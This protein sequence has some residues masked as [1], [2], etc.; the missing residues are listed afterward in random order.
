MDRLVKEMADNPTVQPFTPVVH[1]TRKRYATHL[2][3]TLSGMPLSPHATP[4]LHSQTPQTLAAAGGFT[5]ASTFFRLARELKDAQVELE[6][7]RGE[8]LHRQAD[9]ADRD[10]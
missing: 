9:G 1:R 2:E 4:S 6:R 5:S 3:Q 10:G 7:V 8:R